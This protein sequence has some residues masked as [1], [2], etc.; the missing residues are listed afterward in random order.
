MTVS[1]RGTGQGS[2]ASPL[3]ANIYL[4]IAVSQNA[5]TGPI[6]M[7]IIER[8]HAGQVARSMRMAATLKPALSLCTG[9]EYP[10]AWQAGRGR[11]SAPRSRRS[12][13]AVYG[14]TP[15]QATSPDTGRRSTVRSSTSSSPPTTS[16]FIRTYQLHRSLKRQSRQAIGLLLKLSAANFEGCA[17]AISMGW[18]HT[19]GHALRPFAGGIWGESKAEALCFRWLR[20]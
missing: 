14:A 1:D 8:R 17:S 2:V 15:K 3:L 16:E 9:M 6:P 12:G 7:T 19:Y 5:K 20:C 4:H 10:A 13:P 18:H 11:S